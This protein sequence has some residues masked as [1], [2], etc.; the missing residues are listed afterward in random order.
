MFWGC[1]WATSTFNYLHRFSIGLRSRD[2]LGHSRPWNAFYL[3][4]FSF[5][6]LCVW[7]LWH[8]GKSS[9]V[10]SSMLLLMEGGVCPKFQD[11]WPHSSFAWYGT[12]IQFPFQKNSPQSMFP[13]PFFTVGMMFL[14]CGSA[15]FPVQTCSRTHTGFHAG[16]TRKLHTK[17]VQGWGPNPQH[18]FDFLNIWK[19][20]KTFDFHVDWHHFQAAG[21]DVEATFLA[22]KGLPSVKTKKNIG[23]MT[24]GRPLFSRGLVK[25]H[26]AKL[27]H[28]FRLSFQFFWDLYIVCLTNI[29]CRR[30]EARNGEGNILFM[31][32]WKTNQS[33]F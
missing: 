28:C 4:T 30:Q 21:T 26:D 24:S 8:A 13:L 22:E 1:C 5:L 14:G 23:T 6:R 11:T 10:S 20:T 27:W 18:S 29:E 3:F 19:R 25:E 12:V 2:W 33:D 16:G 31:N 9:H 15:F 32:I 17:K 7:G